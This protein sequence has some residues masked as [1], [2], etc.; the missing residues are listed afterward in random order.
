M[1]SRLHILRCTALS[2]IRVCVWIVLFRGL[3]TCS[4]I[5]IHMYRLMNSVNR[6]VNFKTVKSNYQPNCRAT[7]LMLLSKDMKSHHPSS[8]LSFHSRIIRSHSFFSSFFL[9]LFIFTF[10]CFNLLVGC[11]VGFYFC[12]HRFRLQSFSFFTQNGIY[13]NIDC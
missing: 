4:F 11:F 5:L 1:P 13:F 6:L 2:A 9:F 12:F 3:F 10:L 7:S 8:S